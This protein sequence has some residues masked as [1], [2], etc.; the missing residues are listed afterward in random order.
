MQ[1]SFLISPRNLQHEF[2]SY[3]PDFGVSGNWNKANA[4]LF[5]QAIE[6][7]I[8]AAP[9]IMPGTFRGVVVV[10]HYYDPAT[11]LWAAFDQTNTFVAGWKLYRT[12]I[13]D[14]LNKGDVK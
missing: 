9:V 11:A 8:A 13:A 12:Q 10:T 1:K 6:S 5:K 7:H 2:S 14:L 4:D 3:A